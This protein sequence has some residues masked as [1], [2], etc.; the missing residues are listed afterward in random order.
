LSEIETFLQSLKA[1]YIH[2]DFSGKGWHELRE[3]ALLNKRI[4]RSFFKKSDGGLVLQSFLFKTLAAGDSRTPGFTPGGQHRT[5]L[6][7]TEEEALDLVYGVN[8]ASR[9]TIRKN[10]I[11][12][13]ILPRGTD[14]TAETVERFFERTP[15]PDIASVGADAEGEFRREMEP[16]FSFLSCEQEEERQIVKFDF[17]FSK[18]GGTQPDVDMIELTGVERSK[19][20]RIS[21]RIAKIR[22]KIQDERERSLASLF[23]KTAS[24]ALRPITITGALNNAFGDVT[25]EK[26]KYQRHLLAVLPKIYTDTYHRDPVLLQSLIR[27]TE[28]SIRNGSSHYSYLKYDFAFLTSIQT[29]GETRLMELK[30]S[31]SYRIGLHLGQ[32][33]QPL[34]REINSFEKNYVGLLSRRIGTPADVIGFANDLRQKL[35]MHEK[36]YTSIRAASAALSE[37]LPHCTP[38]NR[39]ECAF[40]FFESYFAPFKGPEIP[41][42]SGGESDQPE[43]NQTNL[44]AQ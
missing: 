4:V 43:L 22:D 16:S 33:A 6:F 14:M 29:S 34:G 3:L 25:T 11:K 37:E 9:S 35:V 19:L 26:K 30:N 39:D 32:L 13:V 31:P 7:K 28:A 5:H 44:L 8:Y 1:V 42:P 17:I 20:S 21:S 10:D 40:G 27:T 38:Y 15:R 23:G 36:L 41:P 2:F 12:V 24:A 18:A